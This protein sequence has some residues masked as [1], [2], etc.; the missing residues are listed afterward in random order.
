MNPTIILVGAGA[1][2]PELISVKGMKTLQQAKVILHDATIH[3]DLLQYAPKK[4]L[5]IDIS[6]PMPPHPFQQLEINQLVVDYAKQYKEIVLL[7]DSDSLFLGNGYA[8][9]NYAEQLGI[10]TKVIPSLSSL[11]LLPSQKTPLCYEGLNHSFWCI[12]A[13]NSLGEL[14][15]ELYL[16][17]HTQ[18]TIVIHKGLQ[19]LKEIVSIFQKAGKGE[20]PIAIIQT[21]GS[22]KTTLGKINTIEAAIAEQVSNTSAIIVIGKTVGLHPS[23]RKKPI[24]NSF[25][26]KQPEQ[27]HLNEPQKA[28]PFLQRAYQYIKQMYTFL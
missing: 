24:T 11:H 7:K 28:K 20:I 12:T 8:E 2:D 16:A 14:S 6:S 26:G 5:K 3:P 22:E 9:I 23:F 13:V 21:S 1:N 17:S 19:R 15:D 18:A 4:A 10:T 27:I 25:I